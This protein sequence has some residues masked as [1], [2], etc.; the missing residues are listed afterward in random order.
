MNYFSNELR[1]GGGTR[2]ITHTS[3]THHLLLD[4]KTG[5]QKVHIHARR[6]PNRE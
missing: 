3:Y 5:K 2:E 6:E 4:N 1:G